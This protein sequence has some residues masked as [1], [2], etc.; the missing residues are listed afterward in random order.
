MLDSIPH[1]KKQAVGFWETE[2]Q[3]LRSL[4]RIHQP[5]SVENSEQQHCEW[6]HHGHS[7]KT[8]STTAALISI[9]CHRQ[10]MPINTGKRSK[11]PPARENEYYPMELFLALQNNCQITQLRMT[12]VFGW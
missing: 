6:P 5:N 2:G 10:L 1:T 12:K 9:N 3:L 4:T 7:G 11:K 8:T